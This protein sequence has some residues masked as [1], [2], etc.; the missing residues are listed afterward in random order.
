MKKENYYKLIWGI[1]ALLVVGFAI[2]LGADY[3][4][5]DPITTSAPFY[6]Y[7]IVRAFEFILP[8]ILTF[9]AAAICKRKFTK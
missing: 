9:I 8:S 3:Y 2:R 5:Y 7:I 1:S 6:T 4:K